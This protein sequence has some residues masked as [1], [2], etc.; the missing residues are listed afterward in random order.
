[1]KS[2]G[3]LADFKCLFGI[4]RLIGYLLTQDGEIELILMRHR[5]LSPPLKF[6]AAS[7]WSGWRHFAKLRFAVGSANG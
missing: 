4:S 7:T 3:S 1:M 2:L 5:K 6:M